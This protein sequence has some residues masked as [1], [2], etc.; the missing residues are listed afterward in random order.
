MAKFL[1]A[2]EPETGG[3]SGGVTAGVEELLLGYGIE[4]GL[5]GAGLLALAAL[6]L[7]VSLVKLLQ[8]LH[9]RLIARVAE[10]KVVEAEPAI[11]G[12]FHPVITYEDRTG[13][14]R[15]FVAETRTVEDPTGGRVL[16]RTDGDRPRLSGRA[17]SALREAA[18][19][20]LPFALGLAAGLTGL[21]G[22]LAG[23]APLPFG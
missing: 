21:T 17:P 18:W 4:T 7:A 15:R 3:A 9:A 2:P 12:G 20:A 11:G 19:L 22:K 8:L 16:V 23:I 5:I 14:R 1:K 13:R 6:C 10:G